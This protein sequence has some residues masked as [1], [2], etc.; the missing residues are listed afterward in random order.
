[1]LRAVY[2]DCFSGA[3]GDMLL[4]ALIDAGASLDDLRSGLSALPVGGW[5]LDAEP[6]GQHGLHG[7]RAKVKLHAADQPHRGLSDVLRIVRGGGLP[8]DVVERAVSVFQRLADVEAHIHRTSVNEVEFHEVGAIDAI[9]D[10]VGVSLGLH[11]LQV[12]WARVYCS[13][14]PLGSGWVRSAHGRLPVPAPATWSWCGEPA[15][16]SAPIP[17]PTRRAS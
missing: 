13:A 17:A 16:R 8:Q 7:T 10:V 2:V 4:G 14:L 15:R 12:D 9:V 6:A 5:T 11:L 1:M 3:S